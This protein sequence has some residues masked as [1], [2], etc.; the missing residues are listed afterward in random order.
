MTTQLSPH[1]SL[2]ELVASVTADR[3]GIDNTP[4]PDIVAALT[5]TCAVALEPAR[6][7]WGVPVHVDSGY[8]CPA[9]NS[10]VHGADRPG[11]ISEHEFGRA[12][13]LIPQGIVLLDAFKA[14]RASGIQFD[15]LIIEE[16]EWIHLGITDEGVAPRLQCL[17]A[18]GTPGHWT[19]SPYTD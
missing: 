18:V 5:R 4:S 17:V 3:L 1:F 11:H 10:A 13:D 12:A 8:R 2:E 7:I 14:I 19:Y 16:N 9:L 6:A 15:Q